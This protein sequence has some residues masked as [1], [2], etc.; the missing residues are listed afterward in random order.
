VWA[1]QLIRAFTTTVALALCCAAPAAAAPVAQ[2]SSEGALAAHGGWVVWDDRVEGAHVLMALR[3]G[4]VTRLPVPA[5]A[6]P[7]DVDLGTD[8]AGR[9]VATYSRCVDVH[10]RSGCAIFVLDLE[11]GREEAARIPRPAGASDTSPSMWRGR[12]AFARTPRGSLVDRVLLWSPR[13]RRTTTLPRGPVTKPEL[14]KGGE[15]CDTF[16]RDGVATD[17]DLGG[18]V[19]A[20]VWENTERIEVRAVRLSGA[21]GRRLGQGHA[22]EV[23]LGHRGSVDVSRPARPVVDGDRVTWTTLEVLCEEQARSFVTSAD[24]RTGRSTRT[25]LPGKVVRVA[26]DGATRYALVNQDPQVGYQ[27]CSERVA[28]SIDRLE[29]VT[30]R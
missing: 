15:R 6:L 11:S 3:D 30:A 26:R 24:S 12:I 18:R 10:A 22:G 21:R 4:V 8:A 7:F 16:P 29:G 17:L 23:C 2:T 5:R 28:C 1:V 20:Y 19:L 25:P 13:T 27:P 14:C 9:T